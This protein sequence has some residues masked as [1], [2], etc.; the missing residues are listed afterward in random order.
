MLYYA[1]ILI[2]YIYGGEY[3]FIHNI[4]IHNTMKELNVF[5]RLEHRSKVTDILQKYRADISFFE[6]L[7]TGITPSAAPDVVHSYRTGRTLSL[8]S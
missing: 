6:V 2:V 4:H 8:N 5:I 1:I 3:F 7:G